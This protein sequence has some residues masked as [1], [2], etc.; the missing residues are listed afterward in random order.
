MIRR[1]F[2]IEDLELSL[3]KLYGVDGIKVMNTILP[4]IIMDFQKVLVDR[5][6][7][8]EVTEEYRLEDGKG[9]IQ[10]K[11]RRTP[12]GDMTIDGIEVL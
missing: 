8:D 7:S 2:N 1:N 9:V 10:V 6:G 12:D 4:G 5:D 11:G 3:T